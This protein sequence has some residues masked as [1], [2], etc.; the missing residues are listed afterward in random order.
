MNAYAANKALVDFWLARWPAACAALGEPTLPTIALDNEIAAEMDG[1]YV[2]LTIRELT[3]SQATIG[4]VGHRKARRNCQLLIGITVPSGDKG[5][6]RGLGFAGASRQL[7]ECERPP[8]FNITPG[9]VEA[10][11]NGGAEP[12]WWNVL[13]RVPF[14]YFETF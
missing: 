6:K 8:F 3:A 7:F 4:R 11:D 1:G 5:A 14:W 9:T 2:R 12:R 10:G 13:V